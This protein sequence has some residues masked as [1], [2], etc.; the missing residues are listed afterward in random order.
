[1]RA[2]QTE[3]RET[4]SSDTPRL[5]LWASEE[6]AWKDEMRA[7][8]TEMRETGSSDTPRLNLWASEEQARI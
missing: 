6:Q 3:M 5:N 1:M 7:V 2:V 4:G 8:Q